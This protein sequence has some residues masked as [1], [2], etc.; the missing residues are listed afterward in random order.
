MSAVDYLQ[1]PASD[2]QFGRIHLEVQYSHLG[3]VLHGDGSM[4]QEAR[5]RSGLATSAYR[6][7]GKLLLSNSDID[8]A[9]RKQFFDS[10]IAGVF[11]NLALWTPCCK[12]WD[13][14]EKGYGLLQRR[15][16]QTHLSKDELFV[17]H[18]LD[19]SATLDMPSL[20]LLCRMRRLVFFGTLLEVGNDSLWALLRLEGAWIRQVC[21]DLRRL[22]FNAKPDLPFPDQQSWSDR[23][24]HIVGQRSNFRALVKR[25]GLVAQKQDRLESLTLRALRAM[26]SW[27][28][29][30]CPEQTR[31]IPKPYWCGPCVRS[32]ALGVWLGFVVRRVAHSA[33][34][35]SFGEQQ[36]ALHLR[37]SKSCCDT[38]SLSGYWSDAILP[39]I[40]SSVWVDACRRDLGLTL[41]AAPKFD[42][43]SESDPLLV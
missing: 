21:D 27:E 24:E 5:L 39:G 42:V 35:G 34:V 36:L 4:L 17:F 29:Q 31:P 19:A 33:M 14:L 13:H 25:A 3:T 8:V 26:G 22:W 41:P 40:G 43:P 28:L 32:F 9:I 11:F 16:L 15:L 30:Q 20:S 10:L 18:C 7:Y 1:V 37:A 38:L 23:R 12:G 2:G 6:K